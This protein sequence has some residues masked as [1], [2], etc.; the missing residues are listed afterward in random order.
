MGRGDGVDRLLGLL[1]TLCAGVMVG[2]MAGYA[3]RSFEGVL[4][5][6]TARNW[7][8]HK[9]R[10]CGSLGSPD[11][12]HY[13]AY[14]EK[15]LQLPLKLHKGGCHCGALTFE[16]EAPTT[17][18]AIE[19]TS[20]L[21]Y[22]S[23]V[24]PSGRFRL[25]SDE[26]SSA[27]YLLKHCPHEGEPG[28]VISAHMFCRH[29]GVHVV[30]APN[31]PTSSTAGVNYH[32][33]DT[34]TV[35][36]MTVSFVSAD[37]GIPGWGDPVSRE[38]G[39]RLVSE[40]LPPKLAEL[41]HVF[42]PAAAVP[43]PRAQP[44]DHPAGTV[45]TPITDAVRRHR[46]Q[47]KALGSGGWLGRADSED[48]WAGM[49]LRVM[50]MPMGGGGAEQWSSGVGGEDHHRGDVG[51]SSAS[52]ICSSRDEVAVGAAPAQDEL[53]A[54]EGVSPGPEAKWSSWEAGRA[55]AWGE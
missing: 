16:F 24:V 21:R 49:L 41:A 19:G 10:K 11:D 43:R 7:R 47:A 39:I 42:G 48:T 17:L 38:E 52:R 53:P 1:A 26:S 36:E 55:R 15:G 2:A 13:S 31:F 6:R 28:C 37:G 34:S 14:I 33:V 22:P 45:S 40:C 3:K 51:N 20:K 54:N 30:H 9:R 44:P 23:V 25:T 35:K 4:D 12:Y 50:S 32:C 27:L 46:Q 5:R 8:K 18:A 29:C